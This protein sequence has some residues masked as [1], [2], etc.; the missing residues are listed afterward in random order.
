[1]PTRNMANRND[2]HRHA[3][4]M[5]FPCSC[6][7]M[8]QK[9]INF[10]ADIATAPTLQCRMNGFMTYRKMDTASGIISSQEAHSSERFS[11]FTPIPCK[12]FNILCKAKRYGRWWVLK[13]LKEQ[14]RQDENYKNLLHKEFDILISLQHPNIVSAYSMEEIPEMG[15]CIVMEW[16]DGIT[17]EHWSGRKTEGEDIFLQL[18]DAVHYIHAKQIVHR[19]LKPSN[20]IITHNGNYVKL[21]DFGLSDTDDFAILKQPAG[22]PGYI[23]P[24]Q[25]AS[26]QADIRNDIFSIG[27]ILEKILPGKPYTAIIKRCKAPIAQRYANVDEL[28]ADFMARRNR[29]QSVIMRIAIAALVCIILLGFISYPLLHQQEKSISITP[30]HHEA[31]KDTVIRQQTKKP[32]P[33]SNGRKS[34]QPTA[35]E[36][37]SA[38]H[39]QSAELIS[40]G[41]KTIDKMWKESGIDTIQSVVKKSEAFNQFVEKSNEF[42]TTTYPQTFSKDID[43]KADIIYEL[44]SYTAERYVKPTLSSFQSSK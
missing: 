35:T 11:D 25:A 29:H 17:L 12:G 37:S 4:R 34:L 13:G 36:P 3:R 43:G 20:I 31:K 8:L 19:D 26:R 6:L 44:S 32:A 22:T 1:M 41:K 14:Y 28:K 2:G 42:I 21:I 38:S 15:T 10:V 30:A 40:K 39:L 5:N 27:C 24:E 18:L 23:S 16:I 9:N 33:L 7:A